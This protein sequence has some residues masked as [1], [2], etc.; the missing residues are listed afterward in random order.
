MNELIEV[1]G[2]IITGALRGGVGVGVGVCATASICRNDPISSETPIHRRVLE[3]RMRS[4][5][6]LELL[7]PAHAKNG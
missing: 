2:A 5:P 1:N 7:N 3:I 4:S 6:S